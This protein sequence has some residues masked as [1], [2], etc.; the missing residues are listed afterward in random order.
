VKF[1]G[2]IAFPVL[3]K[4]LFGKQYL[5]KRKS[6][7]EKLKSVYI[8]QMTSTVFMNAVYLAMNSVELFIF[9]SEEKKEKEN[10]NTCQSYR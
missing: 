5:S 8:P 4:F 9:Q 3:P 2:K 6:M 10:C 7:K 1:I